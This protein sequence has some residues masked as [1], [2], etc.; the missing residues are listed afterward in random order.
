MRFGKGS[1]LSVAQGV[2]RLVKQRKG[3]SVESYS[4]GREQGFAIDNGAGGENYRKVAFA[5]FRNSDEIVVY[6]GRG[7]LAFDMSGNTPSEQTYASKK[8]FQPGDYKGA[9]AFIN[10]FF[11]VKQ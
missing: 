10:K 4:N 5:E 6:A 8:F 9:A 11:E 7:Y 2:L 3:L 1:K